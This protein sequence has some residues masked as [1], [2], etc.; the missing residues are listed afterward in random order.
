MEQNYNLIQRL[1][2]INAVLR[3]T[4][5]S[6]I[7]HYAGISELALFPDY[8]KIGVLTVGLFNDNPQVRKLAADVLKQ[9][10]DLG[11]SSTAVLQLLE[12]DAEGLQEAIYHQDQD[13]FK[14]LLSKVEPLLRQ[15]HTKEVDGS[16]LR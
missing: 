12:N 8:R 10:Y 13:K 15:Q 9:T 6:V 4:D 14:E 7:E 2:E 3:D 11:N 5:K 16:T 1:K